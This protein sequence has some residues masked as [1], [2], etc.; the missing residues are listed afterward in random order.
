MMTS[1]TGHPNKRSRSR[2]FTLIEL[3]LVL[4]LLVIAV[5][6]VSPRVSAFVR[7]RTLH[8]EA[9]RLLAVIRA[10]QSRAVSEGFPASVWIGADTGGYGLASDYS[11]PKADL[12]EIN[13]TADED[14][15]LVVTAGTGSPVIFRNMPAI[16]WLPDGAADEGSL[17][18]V[19]LRDSAGGSLWL[20][21][22]VDRRG[23]EIRDQNN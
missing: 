22:S 17:Q 1:A 4:A 12:K 16:R 9:H 10:G 13:F 21:E 14:I 2:G 6:I 23:Y 7:G 5:S 11:N 20:V 18:R 19:E 8:S 15:R 3:I